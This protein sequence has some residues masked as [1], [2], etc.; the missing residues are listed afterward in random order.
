MN[1]NEPVVSVC[2]QCG[3]EFSVRKFLSCSLISVVLPKRPKNGDSLIELRECHCGSHITAELKHIVSV[4]EASAAI[5]LETMMHEAARYCNC[6]K[7][8][9][10]RGV[11]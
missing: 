2:L 10:S 6:P 7:C 4:Q 1:E 11:W 3:C 5:L 9:N 8:K